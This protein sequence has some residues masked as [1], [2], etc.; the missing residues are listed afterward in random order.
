MPLL[1]PLGFP[2]KWQCVIVSYHQL[3]LGLNFLFNIPTYFPWIDLVFLLKSLRSTLLTAL[4]FFSRP[5]NQSLSIKSEFSIFNKCLDA[6]TDRGSHQIKKK[7]TA[8]PIQGGRE[9]VIK[10]SHIWINL[11]YYRAIFWYWETYKCRKKAH[12]KVSRKTYI[13][14]DSVC[15]LVTFFPP[16]VIWLLML[17]LSTKER[18]S[19]QSS[20]VT[21]ELLIFNHFTCELTNKS[22]KLIIELACAVNPMKGQIFGNLW[23]KK[24]NML[25]LL[26]GPLF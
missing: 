26:S 11:K 7:Y 14:Q 19:F 24:I 2:G 17:Y 20:G 22:T 3:N 8:L 4:K 25:G 5:I 15:C 9:P 12:F 13:G 6:H 18:T 10:F 1:Y 23:V 16:P 21:S